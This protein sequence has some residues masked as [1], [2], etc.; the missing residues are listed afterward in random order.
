MP[1]RVDT[2]EFPQRRDHKSALPAWVQNTSDL[3][4]LYEYQSDNEVYL[5]QEDSVY[6]SGRIDALEKLDNRIQQARE[7]INEGGAGKNRAKLEVDGDKIM[8]DVHQNATQ[9]THNGC[10]SVAFSTML[11]SRGVYLTQQD[12]RAYRPYTQEEAESLPPALSRNFNSDSMF[13][14]IEMADL[15]IEAVPNIMMREQSFDPYKTGEGALNYT[16][17]EYLD[18]LTNHIKGQIRETLEKEHTPVALLAGSH[19]R[20][21]V[22][23]EGDTVYYKEPNGDE[24]HPDVTHSMNLKELLR[25]SLVEDGARGVSMT[26]MSDVTLAPDGKTVQVP[27]G[28]KFESDEKGN[29]TVGKTEIMETF[30]LGNDPRRKHGV[31][32]VNR[33]EVGDKKIPMMETVY[34]PKQLNMAALH[35]PV[36]EQGE[37]VSIGDWT[38][39]ENPETAG[40]KPAPENSAEPENTDEMQKPEPSA[41]QEKPEPAKESSKPSDSPVEEV[42]VTET[43][44]AMRDAFHQLPNDQQRMDYFVA[45]WAQIS[46]GAM[47]KEESAMVDRLWEEYTNPRTPDGKVNEALREQRLDAADWA[48]LETKHEIARMENGV[49][50]DRSLAEKI[51]LAGKMESVLGDRVSIDWEKRAEGRVTDPDNFVPEPIKIGP[52]QEISSSQLEQKLGAKDRNA[53]SDKPERRREANRTAHTAR[54][55]G[56]DL[57]QGQGMQRK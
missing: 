46:A 14:P 21:V 57:S 3:N 37:D 53:S 48:Y 5:D 33:V 20:T 25:P 51:I 27:N 42:P 56:T 38:I 1:R 36:W 11:K 29:I 44:A 49:D 15:A 13:S 22:G 19:Y 35:R 54:E 7:Q 24:N 6:L 28:H 47:T 30:D 31:E 8:L 41:V 50:P 39:L 34:V 52:V 9:T 23:I 43:A 4:K 12:V 2:Y 16:E 10:W 18:E 40:P 55:K 32:S 45:A 26:W 17:E